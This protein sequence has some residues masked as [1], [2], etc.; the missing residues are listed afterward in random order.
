MLK[1]NRGFSLVEV[2]VTVGLIGILVGIAVPSYNK[3][4]KNTLSMAIKADV[5]NGHKAY[6]AF[7]AT[8]GD[9]CSS[10]PDAGVN[11]DM[12]SVTYRTKGFFGFSSV[13]V[14]CDA[15][16][17]D[18]I[19]AKGPPAVG[20]YHLSRGYCLDTSTKASTGD[21]QTACTGGTK[22][23]QNV[24]QGV[25]PTADCTLKADSFLLG[26]YS[27]T[28]GL[29]TMFTISQDGRPSQHNNASDCDP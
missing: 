29:N 5:A 3:Y 19:Y 17:Q 20:V 22:V 9:F 21:D 18:V 2:L 24:N 13:D 14:N 23:W 4:K 15:K 6:S 7:N 11:V 10:L 1:S 27:N 26:A 8:E 12:T 28:A 16:P 25:R